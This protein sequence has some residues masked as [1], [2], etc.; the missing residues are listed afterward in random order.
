V[1]QLRFD[2]HDLR[3]DVP[4]PGWYPARIQD[5]RFRRSPSG[6][7]MLE[8]VY[9]VAELNPAYARLAE[10]FVLEGCSAFGLSRTRRRLVELFRACGLDPKPGEEISP[11]ALRGKSIDL[12]LGQDQWK[13]QPRLVVLTHRPCLGVDQATDV[14]S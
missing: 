14:D 4:T 11:L 1:H 3:L 5:T 12:E 13:G 9:S 10:Y 8:V 7:R 6:N 2:A